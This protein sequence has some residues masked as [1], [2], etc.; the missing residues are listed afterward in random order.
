MRAQAKEVKAEKPGKALIQANSSG[1]LKRS[2]YKNNIVSLLPS[3][4]LLKKKVILCFEEKHL[5]FL[6]YCKAFQAIKQS[7]RKRNDPT[8]TTQL[9]T[10]LC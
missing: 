8:P 6:F 4:T 10:Q 1:T 3:E 9:L 2:Q 7:P 5:N